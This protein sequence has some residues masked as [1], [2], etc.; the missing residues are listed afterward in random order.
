[1]YNYVNVKDYERRKEVNI[2]VLFNT[3][4]F[5]CWLVIHLTSQQAKQTA[6]NEMEIFTQF[7]LSIIFHAFHKVRAFYI[8][9]TCRCVVNAANAPSHSQN[10]KAMFNLFQ[11]QGGYMLTVQNH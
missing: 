7:L 9:T 11:V 4:H 5:A 8:Q 1:M 10:F 6:V 2:S 3:V